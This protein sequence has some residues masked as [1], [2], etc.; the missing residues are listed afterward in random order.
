MDGSRQNGL[1]FTGERFARATFPANG[2][3]FELYRPLPAVDWTG[4]NRVSIATRAVRKAPMRGILLGIR[5]H[6]THYQNVRPSPGN[7][8]NFQTFDISS[9]RRDK[10]VGTNFHLM[11]IPGFDRPDDPCIYDI[12][13][14][15]LWYEEPR[16]KSPRQLPEK[17]ANHVSPLEATEPPDRTIPPIQEWFPMGLYDGITFRSDKECEWLFDEMKRLHMNALYVSNGG[18]KGLERILPLA[19]KRG[20][21]LIYQGG[22]EGAMYYEHLATKEAR[23]RSLEKVILPQARAWLPKFRDQW[24]LA[25]WGLTEEIRPELSRELSPYYRLARELMPNNP[26]TVL[27]NNLSAAVV[28]LETNRPLVVTHDC[29]PFFWSP[30]NGPSNPRRSLQYYR[31]NVSSYYQACRRHGASLWMMPQAWG[32]A[33]SAPL[34]PPNYGYRI[35]MRTPE[36]GEIKLQGWVAIAEGA[37]GI[38]FFASVPVSPTQHHLWDHGWTETPNTRAAGE[39]FRQATRVAPLLCRLERDYQEDGFVTGSNRRVLAHSFIRRKAYPGRGR[40]VV[41]ASLDGFDAQTVD[42]SITGADRV[43]DMVNRTEITDRL[44]QIR[45]EAGEGRVLLCGSA[46]D[47]E[48]DCRLIDVELD[49]WE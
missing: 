27:H 24:A 12:D 45:L 43:Y 40:Y 1:A 21:R 33:E 23:R 38:M 16:P 49:K 31:R 7:R 48:Q 32:K 47:F 8:W 39:L 36:A 10:V 42:L 26:P 41:V 11:A 9:F 44:K 28:D 25:A 6:D 3:D 18:P 2:R 30:R 20:V 5:N 14:L 29:Y 17:I 4:Y 35:G 15:C 13:S 22:G 46:E 37:T 19:E 34:D